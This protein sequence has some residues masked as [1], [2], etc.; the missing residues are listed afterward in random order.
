MISSNSSGETGRGSE[1]AGKGDLQAPHF[2]LSE[3]CLAGIRLGLPQDGQLRIMAIVDSL[4]CI[5]AGMGFSEHPSGAKARVVF[6]LYG[7]TKV[8]PF[9]KTAPDGAHTFH[10]D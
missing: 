8:V 10:A 4:M 7:T 1:A 3:R 9:H 5:I 6:G 2:P